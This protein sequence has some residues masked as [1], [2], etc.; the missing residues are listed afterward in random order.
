MVYAVRDAFQRG[1]KGV[2][3]EAATGL[4]KGM[5]IALVAKMVIAKGKRVLIAV[6]RDQLCEQLFASC[7]EQGLMPVMEKGM[8]HASPLSDLVVASIQT[9]QGARLQ[10]WN[11]NHFALVIT[12]EVH[13][14]A[15]KTFKE[16]LNHF[17]AT[18]HL[19]FSATMERHDKAGL[20]HGFQEVVYTMM[21]NPSLSLPGN[22]ITESSSVDRASRVAEITS[23]RSA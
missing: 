4:G 7:V 14:A 3:I 5:V 9:S 17:E 12:D 18:Y 20:W 23:A 11:R 1:V 6:N 13:G 15:S 16:T 2:C 8:Q 19:G 22:C 10:K 21:C